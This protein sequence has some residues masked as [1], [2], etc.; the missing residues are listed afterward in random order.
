MKPLILTALLAVMQ[1][2]SP[3][4]G[5]AASPPSR[6]GDQVESQAEQGKGDAAPASV[7][8]KPDSATAHDK[9]HTKAPKDEQDHVIADVRTL[10]KK[11]GWDELYICL[12]FLLVLVATVTLI[13]IW[14]QAVKTRDAAE[15]TRLNAQAFIDSQLAQIAFKPRRVQPQDLLVKEGHLLIAVDNTGMT[16][17]YDVTY[18]WWAEVL[19]LRFVDFTS[20]ADHSKRSNP[21]VIHPNHDPLI[22]KVKLTKSLTA[23]EI[24]DVKESRRCICVRVY[25]TY[26][27]RFKSGRY[28][29]LGMSVRGDGFMLLPKYNDAN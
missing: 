18:E 19:P 25:V 28:A 20:E 21:A 17:A 26:R 3:V 2:A 11:D 9:A 22:I 7:E 10:P 24:A 15:A 13:A 23:E 27:D 14:Y 5:I 16:P 1:A 8:N 4:P 12:T 29:N 6:G